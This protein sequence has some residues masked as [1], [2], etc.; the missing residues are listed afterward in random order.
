MPLLQV[1]SRSCL[2]RRIIELGR[3]RGAE[4]WLLTAPRNHDP[5]ADAR[6]RLASRN[7]T[8]FE[9]LMAS[10]DEYN[11]ILR[12]VGRETGTLVVDMAEVYERYRDTPIF[13]PSDVVHPA[14]GGQNLEAETLYTA[15][16]RRGWL[17]PR[18]AAQAGG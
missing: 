3:Q 5:D 4:V 16:V 10:H 11:D 1:G 14:Q 17:K 2:S 18:S 13:L 7:K 12:R 6:E 8:D 15:L 9:S